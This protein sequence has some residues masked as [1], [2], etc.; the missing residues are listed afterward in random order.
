MAAR[1]HDGVEDTQFPSLSGSPRHDRFAAHPVPE[2]RVLFK[3]QH[4]GAFLRHCLGE[5]RASNPAIK[6][7]QDDDRLVERSFETMRRRSNQIA[8]MLLKMGLAKGDRVLMM[9]G[10]QIELW[11]FT[12][13]AIKIGVVLVPS[14][15]QLTEQDIR[16][17]ITRGKITATITGW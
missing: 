2:N 15:F 3:H 4:S 7:L 12:L 9:L 8:N 1:R 11:E 14:A 17:R 10:N 5:S 16:D 13:A 6:I